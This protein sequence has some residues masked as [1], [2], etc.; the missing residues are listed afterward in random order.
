MSLNL[1]DAELL[2]ELGL[3]GVETARAA[4]RAGQPTDVVPFRVTFGKPLERPP[5]EGDENETEN[6]FDVQE[7]NAPPKRVPMMVL[8]SNIQRE[9]VRQH[10]FKPPE[11]THE[12]L[13]REK[14]RT[15]PATEN[16]YDNEELID[17]RSGDGTALIMR[18]FVGFV[19]ALGKNIVDKGIERPTLIQK[20]VMP[21]ILTKPEFD[22]LARAETGSGKT[23]AFLFP[24]I[25]LLES[26][27]IKSLAEQTTTFF[28]PET[29]IVSPTRELAQQLGDTAKTYTR[30]TSLRVVITYGEI[31]VPDTLADMAV[32]CNLLISTIG[33][34]MQFVNEKKLKLNR[35][36]FLVLDEADKL[37]FDSI[38][39]KS[40]LKLR[41]LMN[42]HYQLQ[43]KHQTAVDKCSVSPPRILMFSATYGDSESNVAEVLRPGFFRVSVGTNDQLVFASTVKQKLIEVES[44]QQK[45]EV[46]FNLLV[47]LHS[48]TI[49]GSAE[50]VTWRRL[51]TKM[52]SLKRYRAIPINGDRSQK[53]RQNALDEFEHGDSDVLV[54][55]NVAA[56][57]LNLAGG[58]KLIVVNFEL[59]RL[60][61][62]YVHRIGRTGRAG[63]IGR[64][65][66]FID[67]GSLAEVQFRDKLVESIV[68]L[69]KSPPE[70]IRASI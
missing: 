38:F 53:Q 28:A 51:K 66:S 18:D 36:R 24:I 58:N 25:H 26:D 34:L 56:R 12:E 61:E 4:G 31:P 48:G 42:S 54:S 3:L 21:I 49:S 17:V 55:T 15:G 52:L 68:R 45:I 11:R 35:L 2:D 63:N 57:G 47:Q 8:K 67:L 60:V 23:G 44:R 1:A 5:S 32:G 41:D 22:L 6:F 46:L 16:L 65:L 62:D 29:I 70:I 20:C 39:Y 27:R 40:V 43:Q 30:G 19:P 64:A 13:F 37:I 10:K 33:R 69:N 7:D 9:K 14:A 50:G 59:P